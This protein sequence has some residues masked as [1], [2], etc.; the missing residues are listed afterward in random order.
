[1]ANEDYAELELGPDGQFI[2][3]K[4]ASKTVNYSWQE[5]YV[6]PFLAT[7]PEALDQLINAIDQIAGPTTSFKSVVDLGSGKGDILF[8]LA[9]AAS[10]GGKLERRLVGPF[11]GVELDAVLVA[12]SREA[13]SKLGREKEMEFMFV[14][15]DLV[16]KQVFW[17]DHHTLRANDHEITVD[18][19]C[20]SAE[21]I[22]VFLLPAAIAKIIP[23]LR[24]LI[25]AG[26]V[27]ISV[28]WTIEYSGQSL[29]EYR[30]LSINAGE[31][32]VYRRM[33]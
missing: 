16:S 28:L 20:E 17:D 3:P 19:I 31:I 9:A 1:M 21:I 18:R 4:K 22:T 11:V 15:G 12:E 26:K 10:S 8:A 25:E 5:G 6:S 29:E 32:K 7:T 24:Q 23:L 13:A 30:D 14:R 2:I 33:K 27:V